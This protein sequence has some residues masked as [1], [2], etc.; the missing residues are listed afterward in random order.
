MAEFRR[1]YF[2][3]DTELQLAWSVVA[4]DSGV[5]SKL[6]DIDLQLQSAINYL[7][8][9]DADGARVLGL[10]SQK[11][12]AIYAEL[13]GAGSGNEYVT[14]NLS[15][16]GI[17]FTVEQPLEVD[18]ELSLTLVLPDNHATLRLKANVVGC[19]PFENDSKRYL[20]RCRFGD[21]QEM[22]TDQIVAYVNRVQTAG[23]SHRGDSPESL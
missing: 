12:D 9:R 16:S 7:Q 22:A 1:D 17:A 2:R 15:G 23:L 11:I 14:V 5:D 6:G 10:L 18:T 20:C 19:E 8:M 21:N 4:A 3:V 13:S